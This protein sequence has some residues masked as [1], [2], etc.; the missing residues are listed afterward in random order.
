MAARPGRRDRAP[1]HRTASF[2]GDLFLGRV[3]VVVFVGLKASFTRQARIS[4]ADVV[5][6]TGQDDRGQAAE[7]DRRQDLREHVA[8]R[9]VQ[10]FRIPD[11]KRD[12]AFADAAGHDGKHDIEEA[13]VGAETQHG[14]DQGSDHTRRDRAE[15]KRHEYLDEA[16]HQNP[17]IHSQDAADDDAGDEEVEEVGV[18]GELDDRFLDLGRDQ[19]VIGK[20]GGNEGREDRRGTDV[21]QYRDAFAD[22][23]AGEAPDDQHGD[24]HRDL[25]LDVAGIGEP[26]Q[27]RE[28]DHEHRDRDDPD[29][30]IHDLPPAAGPPGFGAAAGSSTKYSLVRVLS[31]PR[32]SFAILPAADSVRDPWSRRH[33]GASPYSISPASPQGRP[34]AAGRHSQAWHCSG[35]RTGR[36]PVSRTDRRMSSADR[37]W[38]P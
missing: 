23:G 33:C 21:A 1:V 9:L 25:A 8:L 5:Q 32:H 24:H 7:H 20:R 22:F 19:L 28:Q 36:S 15:G 4:L 6:D 12:S 37:S 30:C 17:A 27:K 14:P 13:V 11:R 26:H 38:L 18:L 29:P 3:H 10:D 31:E 34:R 2:G 16:L 35:R